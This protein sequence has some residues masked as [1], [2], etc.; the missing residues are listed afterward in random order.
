MI[1]K[2]LTPLLRVQRAKEVN[3]TGTNCDPFVTAVDQELKG[4]YLRWW[5]S[6]WSARSFS[7][8]TEEHAESGQHW[9]N[10]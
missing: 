7:A 3:C 5:I 2:A 1:R 4:S 9:R 8:I 10:L 6:W